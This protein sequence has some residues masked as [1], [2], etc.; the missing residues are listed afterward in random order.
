MKLLSGSAA[1]ATLLA[2]G[3]VHAASFQD[4][5]SA[6][7]ANRVADAERTYA[8]IVA[9]TA[10]APRERAD[11][12]RE[13]GRIAWLVDRDLDRSLARLEAA[14]AAGDG[15]CETG[16]LQVRVLREALQAS[17]AVEAAAR[18][19]PLCGD[20]DE[21]DDVRIQAA[22]AALDA[23]AAARGDARRGYLAVARNQLDAMTEPGRAG[24]WANQARLGLGLLSGQ[25]A[26]ALE[27]WRGYF[28]LPDDRDAPQALADRRGRVGGVFRA[29]LA[30]DATAADQA[31]L[32]ELLMRMGFYREAR[33]LA[34]DADLATRAADDPA[35]RRTAAYFR[36]REGVDTATL[37]INRKLARGGSRGDDTYE[38]EIRRLIATAM[39]DLAAEGDPRVALQA[40]FGLYGTVGETGGYPSMHAGHVV[41]DERRDVAMYGRRGDIRY[42]AVDNMLANGFETWLWD[43]RAATGG[44]AEGGQTIVQV[45]PE[46]A[47]GPLGAW[48]LT[49]ESPALRRY[50]E[51]LIDLER[52]DAEVMARQ[53]VA[54]LPALSQRLRRQAILQVLEK[55]SRP[56]MDAAERRRA[57]LEEYKRAVDQ[58]SI[59]I[60][61]GRHVLD[62]ASGERL[63][64]EALEYR[65]K[66]SELALADYPRLSLAAVDGDTIGTDAPHGKANAR[67]MA[68]YAAWIAAHAAEVPG[69]DPGK[70]AQAQLDKL[71]DEQIRAVARSL[72]PWV[73][74]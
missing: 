19:L 23:A 36:F 62:G 56:G 33:W 20:A 53:A 52:R 58:H 25:P 32:A 43:G 48:E 41:Q 5:L 35:W 29:G 67:I 51:R 55:V 45:R 28:W 10:A 64:S 69:Y 73:S 71:S 17:R 65:A 40:A 11:A 27:G 6:Y 13:L 70:P 7:N 8:A 24:L 66:L 57:F 21:A 30:R 72:D 47:G 4:G 18:F 68:A 3:A 34:A 61:E 2:A 14:A 44:W 1:L 12:A 50:R 42:L 37:A 49:Y 59:F 26:T 74:A 15:A 16:A 46:Y 54:Y 9:D 22:R 39:E 31:A 38:R 63:D 60:H